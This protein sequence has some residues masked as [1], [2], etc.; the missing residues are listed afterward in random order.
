[1][2]NVFKFYALIPFPPHS[3]YVRCSLDTNYS[4]SVFMKSFEFLFSLPLL[5]VAIER[6]IENKGTLI[7]MSFCLLVIKDIRNVFRIICFDMSHNQ[8]FSFGFI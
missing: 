2:S 7:I 3:K 8:F 6:E 5:S 4:I 1:M